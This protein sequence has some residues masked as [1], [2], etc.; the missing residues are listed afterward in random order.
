MDDDIIESEADLERLELEDQATEVGF[1]T[2]REYA[3]L[4]GFQAQLV[5]YYIRRKRIEPET[6][7]CGRKVI[8]VE[9]ADSVML[10]RKQGIVDVRPDE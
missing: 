8:S 9:Q 10:H 1:L 2:P 5:Y 7:K 3:K 4:R 6:C